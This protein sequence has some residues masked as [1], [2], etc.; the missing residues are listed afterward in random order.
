VRWL[1]VALL[2]IAACVP[3]VAPRPTSAPD[4]QRAK[5][6]IVFSGLVQSSYYRPS[7]AALLTAALDALRDEARASGGDADIPTP[8]FDGSRDAFMADFRLFAAA[9]DDLAARN[10]QLQPRRIGEVAIT[11][12]LNVNPDCHTYYVPGRSGGAPHGLAAPLSQNRLQTRMLAGNVGYLSWR[13]F[14][15]PLF[16]QARRALEDLL[17]AGARAWLLD[18]RDNHGGTGPQEM[19]SWFVDGGP[20]WRYVDPDG[21]TTAATAKTELLLPQPYQLPIAVVINARTYSSAEFLTVGLQQRGRARVFGTKSGG[22]LGGI[23]PV[24]LPDGSRVGITESVAVGPISDAPINNVG[25][26][27]DVEVTDGDPIET[28]ANYLRSLTR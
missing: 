3:A 2:V 28:A 5:I 12:M 17:A 21:K 14:D 16:P 11:A 8:R 19:V 1:A 7:G 24:T 25:I 18:V 22:C 10:P 26:T 6:D 13:E 4:I 9:A 15:L 27:P 20:I 23:M